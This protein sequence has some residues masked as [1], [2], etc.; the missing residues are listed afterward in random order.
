MKCVSREIKTMLILCF[1]VFA[2]KPHLQ[3]VCQKSFKAALETISA[4]WASL[5][6]VFET[7]TSDVHSAFLI[8]SSCLI[9]CD[10]MY[11]NLNQTPS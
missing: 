6:I 7:G 9:R 3:D 5:N 11:M 4:C 2:A 10:L 1:V 8:R